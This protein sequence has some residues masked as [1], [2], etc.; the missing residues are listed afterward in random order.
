MFFEDGSYSNFVFCCGWLL[1]WLLL[2]CGVIVGNNCL[3]TA[4]GCR[5]S[6]W[7]H[8][9]ESSEQRRR[10]TLLQQ[11]FNDWT[12]CKCCVGLV[13]FT[14]GEIGIGGGDGHGNN[15][16]FSPCDIL[17]MMIPQM[18]FSCG[19]MQQRII[20]TSVILYLVTDARHQKRNV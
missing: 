3:P 4:S 7:Q 2:N 19:L 15:T 6:A 12:I 5:Q 14:M 13:I 17:T 9:W 8:R 20:D 11:R 16:S 18:V 10:E 1:W